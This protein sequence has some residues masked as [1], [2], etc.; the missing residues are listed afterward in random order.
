MSLA[1]V[2][3]LWFVVQW[4][5]AMYGFATELTGTTGTTFVNYDIRGGGS[6]GFWLAS[7]PMRLVLNPRQVESGF[8]QKAWNMRSFLVLSQVERRVAEHP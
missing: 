2:P 1:V 5:E 3:S 7:G 4:M 8:T 6:A